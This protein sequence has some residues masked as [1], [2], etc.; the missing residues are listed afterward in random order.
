MKTEK[1]KKP[2][3]ND[4]NLGKRV[5]KFRKL[6]HLTQEQLAEK[7]N[8]STKYIQFIETANPEPIFKHFAK[9]SP[10]SGH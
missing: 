4:K 7:V 6:A 8:L 5:K 3:K 10:R 9:N 2:T 1:Q